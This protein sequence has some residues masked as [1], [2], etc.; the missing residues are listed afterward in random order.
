[1]NHALAAALCAAIPGKA[2][3]LA[4][5]ARPWASATFSGARHELTLVVPESA[6]A[7]AW[8]AGLGDHAFTLDDH[9]V[10]DIALVSREA[11][12]GTLRLHLEALTIETA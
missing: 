3:V 1:V 4:R 8:L 6:A 5:T 11:D 9:L 12:G 2:A 10:A 7:V